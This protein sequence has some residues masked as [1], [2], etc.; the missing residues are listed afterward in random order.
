VNRLTLAT[1]LLFA[2][3]SSGDPA[4]DGSVRDLSIPDLFVDHCLP[5]TP[6][7]R[8]S[9]GPCS[10]APANGYCFVEFPSSGF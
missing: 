4:L 3:C 9:E 7:T 6:P 2:A 5:S 10:L 1:T 8:L